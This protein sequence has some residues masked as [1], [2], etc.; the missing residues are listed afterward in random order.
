MTAMKKPELLAPAGDF[1]KLQMA[2]A[3]GADAVYIGGKQFSLRANAKNFD[4]DE[5]RQ[6]IAYAHD[7]NAKVYVGV[8]IFAHNRDFDGLEDYLRAL[9]AMGADAVIVADLGVLAVA[10]Q[11]PGLEIHISTQANVTNYHSAQMYKDLGVSRVILARELSFDEISD[12]TR[13]TTTVDATI[14]KGALTP[15]LDRKS[16]V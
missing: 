4:D 13:R 3:Y 9:K 10:R 11:I 8:N 15:G 12:I 6:A 14:V 16:V 7:R 5:L 2:I 1:E